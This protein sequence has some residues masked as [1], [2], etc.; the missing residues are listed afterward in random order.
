MTPAY[1]QRVQTQPAEGVTVV[2]EAIRRASP[3]N[4]EF[5]IEISA[6]APNAAQ[7]IRDQNNRIA[8]ITQA[9]QSLNVQRSDLQTIS[10]NVY[11][12]Y[13]P[14][15][16]AL[17]GFVGG[18]PQLG[19]ALGLQQGGLGM[20]P[21]MQFGSYQAKTLMRVTVREPNRVGE[22]LDAIT[23]AGATLVGS[24]SF[25]VSDESVA[26]RAAL[27][28]AGRDARAKAETLAQ[29]AGKQVGDAVSI[30]E[31]IIACNGAYTALRSAN[32]F[33]F[34]PAAPPLAGELEYY[35]RVT[36]SFRLQ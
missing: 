9:T 29:A 13:A 25:R 36:A 28:A 17:P 23:R 11:N 33:M 5:L 2:G 31:D 10:A 4:A 1:A 3:E 18:S 15:M 8:Q 21:E 26:R 34:G 12:V 20:Q 35:A 24:F 27:E 19:A 32:P 30:T 7:A 22:I 6:N 16:P 14:V